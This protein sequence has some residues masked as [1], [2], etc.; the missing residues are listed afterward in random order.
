MWK[1]SLNKDI[2][3]IGGA[4]L[5]YKNG[6]NGHGLIANLTCYLVEVIMESNLFCNNI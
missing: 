5:V 1:G 3:Y 6:Y 2:L 4:I